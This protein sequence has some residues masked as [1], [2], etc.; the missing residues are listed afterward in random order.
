[1]GGGSL[2]RGGGWLGRGDGR[3]T[4]IATKSAIRAHAI[5]ETFAL[6]SDTR[7]WENHANSEQQQQASKVRPFHNRLRWAADRSAGSSDGRRIARQGRGFQPQ[8]PLE[9]SS[10]SWSPRCS[11]TTLWMHPETT[12][13]AGARNALKRPPGNPWDEFA[14]WCLKCSKTSLWRHPGTTLRAGTR[15]APKRPSKS[16]GA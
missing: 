1:M 7:L 13:R 5:Y 8:G 16:N 11:K 12:L 3:I 4:Q 6:P 2:G 10:R 9:R 14:S 15:N